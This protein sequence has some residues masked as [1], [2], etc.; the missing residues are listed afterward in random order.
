MASRCDPSRRCKPMRYDPP[1]FLDQGETAL[2]V[3]FGDTVD[4]EINARVL[5]L[6][7]ALLNDPPAG[8]RETTPTYRA[9]LVRYEPLEIS[10]SAL[11]DDIALR[12]ANIASATPF[13][14]RRWSIPCCYDPALAED[15]AEAAGVLGL[16]VDALARLHANADYRAYMY[17]FAPGWCYLGG[18]PAAL[19]LPRRLT[20]RGLTPEGAV[21]IG[22]GLSLIGAN[23][24]PTGWYVIGRTPEKLFAPARQPS[25][26]IAPGDAIRFEPIDGSTF[27]SLAARAADGETLA[28]CEAA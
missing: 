20:P 27:A 26:L 17:G 10:R 14:G 28:R 1:R 5:A 19:A 8:L 21:L 22:G 23:P 3:E 15:I 2:S 7:A 12:V 4:P 6:D 18:L 24:M 13:A 25:F 11:V 16:T 9:L